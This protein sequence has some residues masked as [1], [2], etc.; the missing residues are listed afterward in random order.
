MWYTVASN[1]RLP[2]L[3]SSRELGLKGGRANVS[4]GFAAPSPGPFVCVL[5]PHGGSDLY[6]RVLGSSPRPVLIKISDKK[7][8]EKGREKNLILKRVPWRKTSEEEEGKR[9]RKLPGEKNAN[10]LKREEP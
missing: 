5:P 3:E 4:G 10:T 6:Q 1:G 7:R 2:G 8:G 9:K